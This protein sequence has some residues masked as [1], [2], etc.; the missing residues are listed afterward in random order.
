MPVLVLDELQKLLSKINFELDAIS[1]VD[2]EK[3]IKFFILKTCF[4]GKVTHVL[5]SL[6]HPLSVNFCRSFNELRVNFFS[7][8][9]EVQPDLIRS[10]VFSSCEFGGVGFTK[11]SILCQA[12]FL[13]GGKNFI[14]EFAG[15][16]PCYL[17]LIN[18]STNEYLK[19][20]EDSLDRIP[21]EI[22]IQFFPKD[23]C[24]IPVRSLLKLRYCVK[25]LQYKLTKILD[26]L[27]Y[28][29]RLGLVKE[30]NPAV[31]T[32]LL[33]VT[34]SSASCI[35]TEIPQVYGLLLDNPTWLLNMRLRCFLWP[36]IISHC[37]VCK[38]GKNLTPTHL[39]NCNR[40]ITFR[41]KVHDAVR[42]QIY[43]I[44]KSYR[45][46]S[47]LEPV[48]SELVDVIEKSTCGDSRGDLLVPR[49]LY[50]SPVCN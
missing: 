49:N 34:D 1:R 44:T 4:S 22:W 20:L 37:L 19:N 40:L 50:L 36:D 17:Q 46:E 26:S 12:A 10:H 3:H 35:V 21:S 45:I 2:V 39:F 27:D 28:V 24:E 11:A 5:R 25:K 6:P 30:N 9:L 23:V 38:C 41:S 18:A 7:S 15:R 42:D 16:Y 14:F 47:F 8:L 32:F 29:V 43:Y 13:G 33:D 31:A 48:L